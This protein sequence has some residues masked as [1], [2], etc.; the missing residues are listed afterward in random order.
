MKNENPQETNEIRWRP[1]QV[2]HTVVTEGGI[3]AAAR[4]LGIKQP[5]V[6]L[7]MRQLA[8]TL[9]T[10]LIVSGAGSKGLH[11]TPAGELLA[12]TCR[13]IFGTW[14]E[15]EEDLAKLQASQPKPILRVVAAHTAKYVVPL[16]LG[17]FQ[18][19]HPEWEVELSL[20]D[21][22]VV[23][24]RL[25]EERGILGVL[26][27]PPPDGSMRAIAFLEQPL[28]VIAPVTDPRSSKKHSVDVLANV[29][30]LMRE[31]GSGTRLRT[32]RFFSEHKIQPRVRMSLRSN[33][34]LR[35]G[36]AGGLG[37][38]IVPRLALTHH[39]EE[40]R[41]VEV[42]GFPLKGSWY[43][44]QAAGTIAT[45]PE[46]AFLKFLQDP[47]E[48]KWW[49]EHGMGNAIRNDNAQENSSY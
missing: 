14:Q 8:E 30:I 26:S 4:A 6:S 18:N 34:A 5:T 41:I 11:L 35:Q 19:E 3:S 47:E 48:Q 13:R 28:V 42:D 2:F 40:I 17:R 7:Q 29:P 43:A 36:V 15:F 12:N 32:E 46:A 1:L 37:W 23:L 45:P 22:D 20:E 10:E 24:R 16:L 49:K 27:V 39:E 31:S 33:E 25:R 44:V 38:A 21:R 9:G